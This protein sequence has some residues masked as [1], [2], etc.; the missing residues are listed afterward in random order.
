LVGRS[1][2]P[3]AAVCA[4]VESPRRWGD[5]GWF[6]QLGPIATT[7]IRRSPI[8]IVSADAAPDLG[9]VAA[10]FSANANP[11]SVETL[12]ESLGLSVESLHRL[13]IGWTGR[14]WSFPMTA[15]GRVCGLRLRYPDGAKL[16]LKGG[17]EGLFVPGDLTTT[18]GS[19]FIAE[20]PTDTAALLDMGFDAVGRPSCT[21]GVRHILDFVAAARWL[22]AVIV[23]DTDAPGQ[24]GARSLAAALAVRCRD[25][26]VITPPHPFKDARAWKQG[27]ATRE[28]VEAL[29]GAAASVT[30]GLQIS[31]GGAWTV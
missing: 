16:A 30:V 31:K 7:P 25:V 2:Q 6:H 18:S 27:G 26:R 22:S 28:E 21:G 14:A 13:G 4:R 5:A 19:L 23:A 17:K 24:A 12:A 1:E 10:K 15:K 8:R 29:V 11:S 9:A 20:G 3:D